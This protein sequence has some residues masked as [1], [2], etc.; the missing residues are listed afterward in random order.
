MRGTH[1]SA[2]LR[3][4]SRAPRSI[5]ISAL[6]E[7]RRQLN[8]EPDYY[9]KLCLP[10][11]AADELLA[12]A[13]SSASSAGRSAQRGRLSPSH[14]R[15]ARPVTVVRRAPG[16]RRL[17]THPIR[18]KPRVRARIPHLDAAAPIG[19]LDLAD[20][21][22]R[23]LP[24][25]FFR[26]GLRERISGG[27][28]EPR[29]GS[30][31]SSPRPHRARQVRPRSSTRDSRRSSPRSPV[32]D[33]FWSPTHHLP[34]SLCSLSNFSHPHSHRFTDLSRFL[35]MCTLHV[36]SILGPG[37]SEARVAFSAV[38]PRD[39]PQLTLPRPQVVACAI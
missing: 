34:V 37:A 25:R 20:P 5:A 31:R 36:V 17:K 27:A 16:A 21:S 19:P 24:K 4:S 18:T 2:R 39:T 6:L 29:K 10:R 11:F 35:H 14:L 9:C 33:Q 38:N 28:R 30:S 12:T 32:L 23:S 15:V 1:E 8:F 7:K 22:A 26:E 3:G 13:E